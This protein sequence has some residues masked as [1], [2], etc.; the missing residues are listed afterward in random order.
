MSTMPII[1]ATSILTN[2]SMVDAL[3]SGG[4]TRD[5]AT[6]VELVYDVADIRKPVAFD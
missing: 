4:I 3:I 5:V 6:N 2:E 1:S